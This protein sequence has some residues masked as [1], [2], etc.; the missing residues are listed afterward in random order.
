MWEE[1]IVYRVEELFQK[2]KFAKK[3][4]KKGQTLNIEDLKLS[5]TKKFQGDSI[6]EASNI[7][8]TQSE[9]LLKTVKRFLKELDEAKKKFIE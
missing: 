1:E 7:L 2:W 8:K 6:K 9:H 3:T 4:L 5:S